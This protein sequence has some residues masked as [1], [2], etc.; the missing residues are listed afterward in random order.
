M[1]LRN[2]QSFPNFPVVNEFIIKLL[3]ELFLLASDEVI[4]TMAFLS[5]AKRKECGKSSEIDSGSTIELHIPI[6]SHSLPT[7]VQ[8]SEKGSDS[9]AMKR[10]SSKKRERTSIP[11][12]RDRD[13][14][15]ERDRDRDKDK[16]RERDRDR[17]KDREKEKDKDRERERDKDR[18]GATQVCSDS[19]RDKDAHHAGPV[20]LET[21]VLNVHT[22][23]SNLLNQQKRLEGLLDQLALSNPSPNQ[24][25]QGASPLLSSP[26]S[27]FFVLTLFYMYIFSTLKGEEGGKKGSGVSEK[28]KGE[29]R[30]E[31]KRIMEENE[32]I[33]GK[34]KK[35]EGK[36]K[37]RR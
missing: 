10:S 34:G 17:E 31:I 12:D 1:K 19:Q 32:I 27:L 25:L 14:H 7:K 2:Q 13:E 15:R 9:P 37:I 33:E 29:R 22:E 35:C 24:L 18:E 8:M 4:R 5:A 16:E 23:V 21:L 26:L 30:I 36:E 28:G 3:Q 20:P 6:L 11:K